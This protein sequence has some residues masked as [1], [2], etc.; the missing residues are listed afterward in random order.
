[1][2]AKPANNKNTTVRRT[3]AE[4]TALSDERMFKAAIDLI[5]ERGTQKTT[6]KEIG[7]RA[8]YSRGLAHARFGSKEGFL[9][10]LFNNFDTLWKAHIEKHVGQQTGIPA[11][12]SA[13]SALRAFLTEESS[14]LRAMYILWYESLGHDSVIRAKL[15]DHH[16]VYRQEAQQWVQAGIDAGDIDSDVNAEQFAVQ[17]CAFIFGIVYQWL[18]NSEALDLD[19]IFIHYDHTVDR[20]LDRRN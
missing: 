13:A 7:E 10:Q 8:G 6:L 2:Q 20:L 19:A 5:V 14:Y 4:R 16:H 15:A 11:I 18:V 17:Y 12:K 1:M 3:Q 9:I